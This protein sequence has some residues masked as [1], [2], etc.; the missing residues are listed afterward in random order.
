MRT[1]K[2]ETLL[3]VVAAV[4]SNQIVAPLVKHFQ[5]HKYT[6]PLNNEDLNHKTPSDR[7]AE[8][9]DVETLKAFIDCK[10]QIAPSV[11][12]LAAYAGRKNLLQYAL[13]QHKMCVNSV[14]IY[15]RSSLHRAIEGG[16]IDIVK[17][18]PAKF[19]VYLWKDAF[20]YSCKLD[21][22]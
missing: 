3:H 22:L 8:N 6:L 1:K 20:T 9:G 21:T 2:Q 14:D 4:G 11:P 17:W 16:R 12:V 13:E 10:I 19:I 7:F 15:Q 18:V 5:I